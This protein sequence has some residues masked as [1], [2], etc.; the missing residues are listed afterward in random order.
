LVEYRL[1]NEKQ[2]FDDVSNDRYYNCEQLVNNDRCS[3]L[4]EYNSV[5]DLDNY[6]RL[7]HNNKWLNEEDVVHRLMTID[8]HKGKRIEW[9]KVC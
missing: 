8:M 3:M 9:V 1:K 6:P 4:K 5:I 7:L 2:W